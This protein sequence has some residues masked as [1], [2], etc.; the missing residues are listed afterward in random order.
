M[1]IFENFLLQNSGYPLQGVI[2]CVG[3]GRAA[4]EVIAVAFPDA[5]G[6]T[7]VMPI[8]ARDVDEEAAVVLVFR[9]TDREAK[10]EAAGMISVTSLLGGDERESDDRI[11]GNNR[12]EDE[13]E[14][15]VSRVISVTSLL[16]G[17]GRESDDSIEGNICAETHGEI[18]VQ[19]NRGSVGESIEPV[20]DDRE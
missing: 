15:V 10:D 12:A 13:D 2:F 20:V 6:A 18:A 17:S 16:A 19:S 14:D 5:V 4:V 8:T 7:P 1:E 9:D 3:R 11:E